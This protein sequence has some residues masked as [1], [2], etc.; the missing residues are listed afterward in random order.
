ML[1]SDFYEIV[2]PKGRSKAYD[3][4]A[5]EGIKNYEKLIAPELCWPLMKLS[6]DCCIDSNSK[7]WICKQLK[8]K[9]NGKRFFWWGI[10]RILAALG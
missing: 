4:C 1:C 10:N 7:K 9:K 2:K 3:T 6:T 8:K 5:I